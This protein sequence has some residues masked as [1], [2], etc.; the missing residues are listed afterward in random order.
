MLEILKMLYLKKEDGMDSKQVEKEEKE[1][2]LLKIKQME[3]FD[4]H[5]P[6]LKYVEDG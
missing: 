5:I 2:G 3:R 6:S 4:V 1:R